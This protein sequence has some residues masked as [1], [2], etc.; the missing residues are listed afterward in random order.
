[1]MTLAWTSMLPGTSFNQK[2]LHLDFELHFRVTII[3]TLHWDF[4]LSEIC[5]KHISYSL[6]VWSSILSETIQSY[7]APKTFSLRY[8][9]VERWKPWYEELL[10]LYIS[11]WKDYI[12][13]KTSH[14]LTS[15]TCWLAA[16]KW[17]STLRSDWSSKIVVYR[18][19]R[20]LK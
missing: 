16:A 3:M 20:I 2:P 6:L 17:V 5:E 15:V 13:G 9:S 10:F 12:P 14:L 18:Y 19:D 11:K 7:W 1:M 4:E 8:E